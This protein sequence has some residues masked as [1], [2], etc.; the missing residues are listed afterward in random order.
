MSNNKNNRMS[1]NTV[2]IT[3]AVFNGIQYTPVLSTPELLNNAFEK[4]EERKIKAIQQ[5]GTI[6]VA[7]GEIETKLYNNPEMNKWFGN[8]K[9]K[10][11][12][13]IDEAVR[14]G[15]YANAMT[16]AIK[17]AGDISEDTEL[18]NRMKAST[19]YKGK[20]DEV[21][22]MRMSNI[23]SPDVEEWWLTNNQFKYE[24]ELDTDGNVVGYKS[25]STLPVPVPNINPIEFTKNS[26]DLI[27]PKKTDN[28]TTNID[29]TGSRTQTQAIYRQDIIDNLD[30]LFTKIPGAKEALYQQ[31]LVD[32]YKYDKLN[33]IE[34]PTL[35]D[36]YRKEQLGK[37]MYRNG[38][39]QSFEEYVATIME[40]NVVA[41][42]LSYNYAFIT[43]DY[44]TNSKKTIKPSNGGSDDDLPDPGN[45][46][47][48][49]TPQTTTE[50]EK[51]STYNNQAK[52]SGDK[53][54]GMAKDYSNPDTNNNTSINTY[55][56]ESRQIAHR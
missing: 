36:T 15:D 14:V 41:T 17:L 10:I 9:D 54:E 13:Q 46:G 50:A 32:Q 47:V 53:I 34:N 26:F 3:P 16:T 43:D 44:E 2:G 45:S 27:T 22:K 21:H 52:Q 24:D 35:D 29:G 12:S 48:S 28:K 19:E 4:Q 38:S 8:Y 1:L 5:A 37:T 55:P 6:D 25:Y 31:Y 30:Y 33:A 7:L 51:Q 39:K 11:K 40:Q 56:S 42:N 23:I 20:V 49:G 18:L